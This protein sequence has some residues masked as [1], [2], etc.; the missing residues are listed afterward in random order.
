[1]RFQL[2]FSRS[3]YY[4]FRLTTP[5]AAS[6]LTLLLAAGR[7][8]AQIKLWG[9][10]SEG[11][12]GYG[13]IFNISPDGSDFNRA[14]APVGILGRRPDRT[15]PLKATNGKF[16]AVTGSG[17]REDSG[18]MFEYDPAGAGTYKVLHEFTQPTGY[19][20]FG[21]LI[22]SGGKFYGMTNQGGDAGFGVIFEYDPAGAGT[23]TVLHHFDYTEGSN[24]G[25]TLL[26]LG[27]KFYGTT[28]NGGTNSYGVLFE[29]DPSN[30]AYNVL[31]HFDL[32]TGAT[33]AGQLMAVGG[34]MY[35]TTQDGGANLWG[36]IYEYD[37]AG[38][39]TYTV[40]YNF[41]NTTGGLPF[42]GVCASGGKFYGTTIYGGTNDGGVLFEYDPAG[43]GTYTVL[44]NFEFSTGIYPYGPVSA[45]G[46]I[47]YGMTT[48]GGDNG[49][50][51][52][53]YK[54]DPAGGGTY[55][56]LQY[57]NAA[58]GYEPY[59]GLIESGGKLY[60]LTLSGGV[61]SNGVMFE[62]NLAG[63]GTYTV[64][65]SFNDSP[66]GDDIQGRLIKSGGKFYGTT[67][68]GGL[69]DNGQIF[70]YDP[71]GSGTYTVL[72][73]FNE[74]DGESPY[75]GVTE[76]DGKFYGVTRFG[77][78]EDMGVLFVYDP[79]GAG[80]YTVLHHFSFWTGGE[81]YGGLTE[82]GGKLY[83]TGLAGGDNGWGVIFEYDPAGS[84]TY[85]VLHHF[86]YDNGGEPV[87]SLTELGG[88]LY[89]TTI[90]GGN[91]N[92]SGVL[93]EYDLAGN[94]Y[95]VLYQ[96]EY[97]T[98][99]EFRG[100]LLVSGG[101]FYGVTR[102]GGANGLGV[103][104]E[105]DPAGSGTYAPLL[106]FDGS[107]N[108]DTPHGS[109]TEVDGRFYGTTLYGGDFGGGTVFEYNPAGPTYT[110]IRHLNYDD[111]I[112]PECTLFADGES[113]VTTVSGKIIWENDGADG[114]GGTLVSLSGDQT[115]AMTTAGNGLY[116]FTVNPGDDLTV[117]PS[118]TANKFNGVTAADATR[119]QQH[120]AGINPITNRY[121][122]VAADVNK[123]NSVTAADASVINQALLGN[124]SAQQQFKTSWRFVPKS[125]VMNNPPWGFPEKIV[126]T[127]ANGA[128]SNQD[129]Y[130]IKTGDVQT[131]F[132]NPDAL[133]AAEALV[134]NVPDQVLQA[135]EQLTLA[136]SANQFADLAALQLALHFD[137]QVLSLAGIAPAAGL[138]L[139]ADNF[140][141]SEV[142]EGRIRVVWSQAAG[143]F[144]GEAAPVFQLTFNVLQGGVRLSDVLRTDEE[145][146]PGRAYTS[147]LAESGVVLHFSGLTGTAD[148]A[149]LGVQLLQNRP[150]PFTGSTTVGFV[151]TEAG[152]AQL[153]VFDAAG[154]L[155][156]ERK[157]YYPAGK[158]AEVFN[159]EGASGVLWYELT[160]TQGVLAKKMTAGR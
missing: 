102:F 118:K 109:L 83:G 31:H 41:D 4:G 99:I 94:Q 114:V 51:G 107:A 44:H 97:S 16:Y 65:F 127:N 53:L 19:D 55:T 156:A 5:L 78:N 104:F 122:L 141:L 42:S 155:L 60:G 91:V 66:N 110:V 38:A 111:G 139:S 100:T 105:Y 25:G 35:S 13:S 96:F 12:N 17:G 138:P 125:H 88:K 59:G 21:S 95:K 123:S 15:T 86:D 82:V 27:G 39:G 135:G 131:G 142:A 64:L 92:F 80:T 116:T 129:F 23:Y 144:V 159:L 73:Q 103:L 63:A 145:T 8:D 67:R 61:A 147:V 149:G 152:D 120:L 121:K 81:S 126:L 14:F 26:D 71:A 150:N 146:L 49:D 54:Y 93:F 2:L 46:S 154:K 130:G 119:I 29:F 112:S 3:R 56:V 72:H 143:T 1:M 106:H 33:P 89:G 158:H 128:V 36:T 40:L 58:T 47:L 76:L 108:G 22:E 7:L 157:G 37:P 160:T 77:G 24:P 9:L 79:A 90:S 69:Y 98:G 113:T 68:D 11:G 101:K 18:I 62:Y 137:P 30:N 70:E 134:L 52:V 74:T 45:S 151:L 34:K 28:P 140:G 133:I 124:A 136:F 87:S 43:S 148:P 115:N 85:T 50:D 84:G 20:P 10:A 75:E 117:T 32:S 132:A 153:R 57:F 48:L 6:L